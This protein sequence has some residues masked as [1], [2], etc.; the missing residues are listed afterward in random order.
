MFVWCSSFW[1][2]EMTNFLVFLG[3]GF[4]LFMHGLV[5]IYYLNLVLSW[6]I[7]VSPSMVIE[8]MVVWVGM[9]VLL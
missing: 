2:V 5:E 8:N 7:L 1:F 6:N 9:L 4:P 3:C